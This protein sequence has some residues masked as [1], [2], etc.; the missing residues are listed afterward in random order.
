M[1]TIRRT[2]QAQGLPL[3]NYTSKFKKTQENVELWEYS[4]VQMSYIIQN[5][6]FI[7]F[8]SQN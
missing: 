6:T 4:A 2:L 5:K 1:I 3:I 8:F 7:C